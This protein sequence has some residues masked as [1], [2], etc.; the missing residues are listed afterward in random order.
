MLWLI[1]T[2]DQV[3]DDDDDVG[4]WAVRQQLTH[5]SAHLKDRNEIARRKAREE[6]RT[7]GEIGRAHV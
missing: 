1:L 3:G 5:T 7:G 4:V 6:C 2:C